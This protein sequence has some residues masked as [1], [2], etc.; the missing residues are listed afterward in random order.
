MSERPRPRIEE[1]HK[2]NRQFKLKRYD[3]EVALTYSDVIKAREKLP[4][5]RRG[6]HHPKTPLPIPK[7]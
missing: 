2:Q 4:V 1:T 5:P 7:Q 6:V 3:T